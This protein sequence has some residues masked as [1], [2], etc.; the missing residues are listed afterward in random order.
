M[1]RVVKLLMLSVLLNI[2]FVVGIEIQKT[3]YENAINTKYEQINQL[4]LRNNTNVAKL[5][6]LIK[7]NQELKDMMADMDHSYPVYFTNYYVGDGSSSKRT[8]SGFTVD[9]FEIN[10]NGM[11]T[12][13]GKVVVA[14]AT[15]E[16]IHSDYGV[17]AEI[18]T[19]PYGYHIYS[20]NDVIRFQFNGVE[21]EGIVLD[22]CGAA[23]RDLGEEYQR[24]DIFI[25]GKEYSFGKNVG[26][27]Y[28]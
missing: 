19:L 23:M 5:I 24:V 16:G 15:W 6:K 2:G 11:Y 25:A 10:E 17:L 26:I 21:Y 7:E 4:E 1:K 13:Q 28:E 9:D 14:A 27:V 3:N 8:G 18:N 20:Y 12:Y 22:T